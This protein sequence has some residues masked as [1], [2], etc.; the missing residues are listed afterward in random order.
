[1]DG[2]TP[3]VKDESA[4]FCGHERYRGAGEG[5]RIPI[6]EMVSLRPHSAQAAIH[7]R[8][9]SARNSH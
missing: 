9:L 1:M 8:M 6:V 5:V 2:R 4:E 3:L 7:D